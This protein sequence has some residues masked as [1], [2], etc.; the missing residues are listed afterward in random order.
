MGED[1]SGH[2]SSSTHWQQT[3]G[4]ILP[5]HKASRSLTRHGFI[6]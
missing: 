3:N 4:R 6:K 5:S 2:P 1:I